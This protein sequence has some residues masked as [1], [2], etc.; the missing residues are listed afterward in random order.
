MSYELDPATIIAA[1]GLNDGANKGFWRLQPRDDEGQWIEMGAEVLAVLRGLRGTKTGVTARYVGPSGT[2]GKARILVSGDSDLPD[3]IYEIDSHV[4]KQVK[5]ILPESYVK[6]QGVKTK[7]EKLSVADADIPTVEEIAKTRTDITDEDRRLAEGKLT[8]A[9]KTAQDEARNESPIAD[10]P[11]GFE[12][13]KREEA[14]KL[15][16]DSG[17]DPNEFEKPKSEVAEGDRIDGL[18]NDALKNA[19][20][21]D[22]APNVDDLIENALDTEPVEVAVRDL[23]PG[24]VVSLGKMGE[25]KVTRVDVKSSGMVDVYVDDFGTERKITPDSIPG[26]AGIMRVAKASDAPAAAPEKK[27][28]SQ[29]PEKPVAARTPKAEKP[30]ATKKPQAPADADRPFDD[31]EL[32][33]R[34]EFAEGEIDQLRK[35]KLAG[36]VNDKGEAVIEHNAKGE[37]YQPKDPNAMLNFLAKT[38]K[39]SKFNDQGQLVLM[40]EVSDENGKSIQ[41]EIRAANTGDKKIAYLFH[42]KDLNTGEEQTLI[43]KDARDSITA[44]LGKTNSPEFLADILTGKQTRIYSNTFDTAK[45]ANDVLERARYF[46]Y[47][48]RTKSVSDSAKYYATGYAD[49]INPS[50]GSLLEKAVPSVFEAFESGD[51]EATEDRLRA[52]FGRLPLDERSHAEARQAIRDL[53]AAR[54][55]EADKRSFGVLVSRASMVMREGLFGSPE[56]RA[57]PYSSKDKISQVQVGMTVEYTNNINEKS[58]V[59]VKALQKVNAAAPSQSDDIFEFGDYVTVVD[60]NGKTTSLPTT[61]LAILKDQNTPLTEYKGRVSGRELREA[62]GL[63]YRP[64]TLLFPGQTEVPDKIAKVD[65]LVPGDNFYSKGGDNLGVVIESVSIIGKDGKKGYGV[66]YINRDGDLKKV[67]VAAG[68]DRGPKNLLSESKETKP[69][70]KKQILVDS[71]ESDPDFDLDAIEFETDPDTVERPK[72]VG[73]DF[74]VPVG[75]KRNAV[76]QLNLNDEVQGELDAMASELSTS[77]DGWTFDT[78]SFN[79][80]TFFKSDAFSKLIAK[81]R[82]EYPD[83]TDS[84][85]RTLLELQHS[86]QRG[87][88]GMTKEKMIEQVLREAASFNKDGGSIRALQVDVKLNKQTNKLELAITPEERAQYLD[89]ITDI[90]NFSSNVKL[91]RLFDPN[92]HSIRIVDTE[93]KFNALYNSIGSGRSNTANT[94]GVNIT[95]VL[96]EKNEQGEDKRRV[97][98]LINNGLLRTGASPEGF[99]NPIG[100]TITH[101]FGHTVH[102]TLEEARFESNSAYAKAYKEYITR[103]GS[104]SKS[105]HFAESFSKYIQLGEASP[106]F[107]QFLQSVGLA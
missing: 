55:P 5:A 50:N 107:F 63:T 2:V 91:G 96:P 47:Q 41:W 86:K 67:A 25:K 7:K 23:K 35:T 69:A 53:Y 94:L 62:R 77:L 27:P 58:I 34:Q 89:A 15:L 95:R 37:P 8:D 82:E 46:A 54:N 72:T 42:F 65:D 76:D 90:E 18:V 52:V 1:I 20:Y 68:E 28:V 56:N 32:I 78:S 44:M 70:A 98:I 100:D 80:K 57:I 99:K 33:P 101:E 61:S 14:K 106:T 29:K 16:Q 87:F 97:M 36:L 64:S 11:G 85:I 93:A 6:A 22:D 38:Y 105:E 19:F 48:G 39:D 26:S 12:S 75:A 84:E 74:N 104:S 49:K 60:A 73:L 45:H 88:F 3:G 79:A 83:L 24:D 40:R 92:M 43:H 21:G 17:V 103:Y 10:L 9:E 66:L 30:K 71:D 13:L 59:K 51:R 102:N 4:L 31:G 81:A